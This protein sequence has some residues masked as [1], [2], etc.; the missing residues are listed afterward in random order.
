MP[1]QKEARI[2]RQ[3]RETR[4]TPDRIMPSARAAF[5]ERSMT[6][7]RIN[8]PLSLTLQTIERLPWVTLTRLPNGRV[9]CAQVNSPERPR[10]P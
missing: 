3:S 9:R 4:T 7:P 5:T 2:A 8:G 10:L 1:A 6:R